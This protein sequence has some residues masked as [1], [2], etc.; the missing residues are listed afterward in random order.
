MEKL[1][2]WMRVNGYSHADLAKMLGMERTI[3]WAY[4]TGKRPVSPRFKW[5]FAQRFGATAAATVFDLDLS[6]SPVEPMAVQP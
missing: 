6:P 5:L 1:S 2:E 3:V 4:A